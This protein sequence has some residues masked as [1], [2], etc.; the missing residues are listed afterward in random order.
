MVVRYVLYSL[1]HGLIL[2]PYMECENAEC[3]VRIVVENSELG[4]YLSV[5]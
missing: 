1:S 2:L 3:S 5:D 4:L